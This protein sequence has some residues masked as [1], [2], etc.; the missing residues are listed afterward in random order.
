MHQPGAGHAIRP[1]VEVL[2]RLARVLRS[3]Q[4]SAVTG[5][6]RRWDGLR[7]GDACTGLDRD[8]VAELDV[9]ERLVDRE[10]EI[11][12]LIARFR[13]VAACRGVHSRFHRVRYELGTSPEFD[14]GGIPRTCTGSAP[15]SCT[16]SSGSRRSTTRC[17]IRV[18][19]TSARSSW[20]RR[21][22]QALWVGAVM[23]RE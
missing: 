14:S 9:R 18:V 16:G 7:L 19:R 12:N 13:A 22:T 20:T 5:S 17:A 1:A 11:C 10:R 23:P 21:R 15:G 2:H 3:S 6:C 8:V 4:R